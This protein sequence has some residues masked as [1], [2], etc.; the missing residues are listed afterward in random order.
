VTINLAQA[1]S[2]EQLELIERAAS[3]RATGE[4]LP[5]VTGTVGFRNLVLASDPRALIPRPETEGLVDRALAVCPTGIAVDVGTGTGCVALAL[6]QEG[7]YRSVVGIEIAPS[8][9]GLA[10]ENRRRLGLDIELVHGDLLTAFR[11]ETADVVVANPPYL[12]TVEYLAVDAG[13]RDYE[14][15]GALVGGVDGLEPTREVLRQA[16]T[17]VRR[18][19]FVVIE[20]AADRARESGEIAARLGWRDV[21]IED[22]LFGRPRY[23]SGQ[24]EAR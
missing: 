20:V 24:R 8:T 15:R 16:A 17:V 19:G 11:A 3:R 13:V 22:D 23:L 7:R 1:V 4:P 2:L 18:G 14:P 9:L 5:Y 10:K 21:R 6:R 12:S